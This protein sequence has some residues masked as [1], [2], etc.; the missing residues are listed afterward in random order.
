M[1][2]DT[3]GMHVVALKTNSRVTMRVVLLAIATSILAALL[4]G[5]I[6]ATEARATPTYNAQ[7]LAFVQLL[8]DY[9]ISLGLQP[10]LISDLL[11]ESSDRHNSDM[12]KYDFFGH[13]TQG[14]DWFAWGASPWDRMAASGYPSNTIQGE[15]I[16]AGYETAAE[17]FAGWKA[18]AGHLANLTEADFR[19]I[20]VSFVYASGSDYGYYWTTDFG[21]Y[22]DST[23]HGRYE[24]NSSKLAYLGTWYGNNSA[25]SASGNSFRYTNVSGSSVTIKFA[26]TYLAWVNKKSSSYGTAQVSVDGGSPTTV[27]L[28][29]ATEA[30]Q[31]KV[32]NTGT[33]DYGTH[34]V[35]ITCDGAGYIGVDAFDVTGVLVQAPVPTRYEQTNSYLAYAGTWF[36]NSSATSASGG[37]FKYSN[38]SGTSVTVKFTGTYLAWITKTSPIYGTA[39]VSVD[40]GSATT[41]SLCSASDAWQQKVWNTGT[42]DSGTHTVTITCNGAGYVGVDAFD[43]TG[44]LNQATAVPTGPIRYEQSNSNLAYSGT[45]YRNYSASSASGGSFWYTNESG[46]SVTVKFTGTYLAWITKKSSAY[47]TA[48]VSVDGGDPTTV[49]LYSS[50]EVWKQSVWNTGTLD[51]GTHTVTITCDGAGYVGVDAFDITGTLHEATVVA[52]API[53]YEQNNS[54][55]AYAGTW[56]TNSSA[57]SA[58]G[59]SFKYSNI[60]GSSVTVDFTGTYLAWIAKKSSVY[61]TAQVTVDGGTPVTVD[62]HNAGDLW[63][64]KVWETGTLDSGTHTVTITCD[65]AG[66]VG[67]DAFDISGTLQ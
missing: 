12:A 38:V 67:V 50:S 34:T 32:W 14:S 10:L 51:S 20:G 31:Q 44:T 3:V 16:A 55:L 40:G 15:N 33:L 52:A 49:S 54:K 48:Q 22:I 66:Y 47:G 45:W 23:S 28:Y 6:L 27:S 36:S 21:G 8:N 24:Q 42:L 58:S 13:Y 19:V 41:V 30:W 25:P 5:S 61:G 37:S 60:S 9:R 2:E 7:E 62:L 57:S 29:S 18:S 65:G 17:V 11:S 56:Y 39:Q 26:G 35:T 1:G 63:K 43:V 46:S 53:R 64:Q 59:G 4:M